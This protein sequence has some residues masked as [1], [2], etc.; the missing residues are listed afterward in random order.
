MNTTI[1]NGDGEQ[2]LSY[3]CKD[4]GN[5]RLRMYLE[6]NLWAAMFERGCEVGCS[7]NSEGVYGGK[8]Y[9]GRDVD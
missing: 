6:C 9:G 8:F 5:Y 2:L 7:E 1:I 3:V 4:L